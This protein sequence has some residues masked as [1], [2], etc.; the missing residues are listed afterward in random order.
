VGERSW[1]VAE[2]N[3]TTAR[4]PPG[5]FVVSPIQRHRQ[6]KQ[7][8]YLIAKKGG[9]GTA[10]LACSVPFFSEHLCA[11]R[12]KYMTCTSYRSWEKSLGLNCEKLMPLCANCMRSS[13]H[14]RREMRSAA[15]H[16]KSTRRR[17]SSA[18][19][20]PAVLRAS[21]PLSMVSSLPPPPLSQVRPR[22]GPPS[23]I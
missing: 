22:F 5:K 13:G 8:E 21:S 14:Q 2:I 16:R 6:E 1:G 9:K 4:T 23:V 3:Q 18:G 10:S 15:L 19:V 20:P 12:T 11:G 17:R 7:V